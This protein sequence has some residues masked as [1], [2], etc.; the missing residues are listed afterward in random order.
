MP[1]ADRLSQLAAAI[2]LAYALSRVIT[3]PPLSL[4]TQLPGVYLEMALNAP[5][6]VTLLVAGLTATGA[7]MLLRSHPALKK[8]T[9]EH[10]LLPAL[11]AWVI[12]VPLVRLPLGPLWLASFAVGGVLLML[13]L[14]AEYI[15]VDPHDL[16]Y[17][18]ASAGLTAVS[19]ALFLALAIVMR[20]T[21][22]RLYLVF[23][24]VVLSA[25][26][27]ILRTLHLRLGGRWLFLESAALVL[28]VGQLAAVLHYLP[29][30][31]ITYGLALLGPT[32]ALT[33]FVASLA[34]G[35][36]WRRAIVEPLVVLVIVWGTAL[37]TV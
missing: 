5:T 32:Y 4:G 11:T 13:V 2:L 36:A 9:F 14:I 10:W 23:P 24:A 1:D 29:L 17:A 19:F 6:V 33:S 21:G 31:P 3:L 34:E 15:A 8:N 27:V 16:R 26:L 30:S 20:S 18:P 25:G 22:S 37:L 12:G 28:I 7:D 35:Q